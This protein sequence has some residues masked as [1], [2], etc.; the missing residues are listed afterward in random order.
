MI[1][2]IHGYVVSVILIKLRITAMAKFLNFEFWF[3][4]SFLFFALYK[5]L[6]QSTSTDPLASGH[7]SYMK[8]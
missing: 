1:E 5:S 6:V 4:H 8:L 7:F 2:V 3:W